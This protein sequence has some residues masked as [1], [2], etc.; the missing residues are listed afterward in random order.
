MSEL[1]GLL[2]IPKAETILLET[3]EGIEGIFKTF[4]IFLRDGVYKIKHK[5]SIQED[6][7]YG[8]LLIREEFEV[9]PL[10]KQQTD[11]L[12]KEYRAKVESKRNKGTSGEEA[13][14]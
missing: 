10:T 9:Y 12:D 4:H 14:S 1:Y 7:D 5:D 3:K 13:D 11:A 2:H 8:I 6:K